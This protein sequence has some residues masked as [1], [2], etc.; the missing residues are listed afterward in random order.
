MAYLTK[1]YYEDTFHG[2]SIPDSQFDRLA[3][4]ASDVI[5]ALVT[6]PI[7]DDVDKDTLAK[8]TA[9]QLEYIYQQGGIEAIT[10]SAAGQHV[11]TEKLDDYSITEQFTASAEQNQLSVNGI[12][13]SPLALSILRK[14]GLMSR[15]LYCP[16]RVRTP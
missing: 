11:T 6:R 9:Y 8:A 14:L 1:D 2:V 7:T 12:P 13:V 5:D 4:A 3:L 15:W 16:G 10:G